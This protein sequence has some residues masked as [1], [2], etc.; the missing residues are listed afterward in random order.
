MVRRYS[1]D[2]LRVLAFALLIAFHVGML[3]V[4]WRYNLKSPRLVPELEWAMLA[5]S[6]WRLP[7]LFIISGVACRFLVEKLGAGR[8]ALNRLRRLLPPILVGMFV[9]I[10]PQT[11]I[12]LVSKG[13]THAGY[14]HF[15]LFSYLRADQTLVRPLHKTMPTW[16]HLWF[17]VYLFIYALVFAL[18]WVLSPRRKAE[19]KQTFSPAALLII[20][21]AFLCAANVLVE[22]WT[23]RTDAF[24]NDWG[25]HLKWVALFATG[26]VIARREGVWQWLSE[27]RA[28]LFCGALLFL[29][30]MLGNHGLWMMGMLDHPWDWIS[31]GMLSGAYGWTMVLAVI[32]YGVRYLNRPSS[33]LSYLNEAILPVYVLHQPILLLAAFVVFQWRLPLPAEAATLVGITGLGSLAIYHTLIRP[34]SIMR[35]LFGVKPMRHGLDTGGAALEASV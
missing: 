33:A 8:F 3:Y 15:W 21:A 17:L 19:A 35:F 25:E 32:G 7:L 22:H 20:P 9:I 2:W 16:D 11:W 34:F 26:I 14:L 12:E 31:W 29:G 6:P 30:L 28:K 13:V 10:P 1:L 27:Q 18:L 5:L 4:T 24:V 23:P